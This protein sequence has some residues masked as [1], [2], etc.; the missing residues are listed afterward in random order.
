MKRLGLLYED[1]KTAFF[2]E[3]GRIQGFLFQ[4]YK[5]EANKQILVR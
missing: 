4:R 2:Y 5:E 3:T 1:K